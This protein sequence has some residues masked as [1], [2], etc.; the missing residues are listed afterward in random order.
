MTDC[1]VGM[2]HTLVGICF[3]R[4]LGQVKVPKVALYK[5]LK[6]DLANLLR[7]NNRLICC[8]IGRCL[9][10]DQMASFIILANE[11]G[12]SPYFLNRISGSSDA[13]Y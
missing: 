8:N 7:S 11:S 5:M 2:K 4:L 3:E 12:S 6:S 1:Y 9:I 10:I 13:P